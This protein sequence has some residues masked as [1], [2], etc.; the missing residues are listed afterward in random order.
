MNHWREG[1]GLDQTATGRAVASACE[2]PTKMN[3]LPGGLSP[4]LPY[5]KLGLL[6]VSR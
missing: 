6:L 1:M 4:D 3:K 2:T 5:P